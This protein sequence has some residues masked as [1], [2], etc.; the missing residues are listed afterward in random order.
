E[1]PVSLTRILPLVVAVEGTV[2]LYESAAAGAEAAT[3]D[4]LLPAL[5]SIFTLAIPAE[6]QVIFCGLP[7]ASFSPPL[8]EVMVMLA[9][10]GAPATKMLPS[11]VTA[12]SVRKAVLK[13]PP[14]AT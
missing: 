12:A 8:G 9:G 14:M 5:Y 1:L 11:A 6:F 4:Q 13:S 10:E 3:S 2:Q 7:A